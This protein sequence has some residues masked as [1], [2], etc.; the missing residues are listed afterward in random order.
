MWTC[1]VNRVLLWYSL[2]SHWYQ[3]Y[4]VHVNGQCA[5]PLSTQSV[6]FFVSFLETEVVQHAV[7]TIRTGKNTYLVCINKSSSVK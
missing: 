5:V 6:P 4:H 1:L 2:E 7:N 3:L